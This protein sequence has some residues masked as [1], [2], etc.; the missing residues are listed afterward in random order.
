MNLKPDFSLYLLADR[1]D[2]LIL[3]CLVD[4]SLIVVNGNVRL[5]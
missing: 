5:F 2:N 1:L 4:F 3:E